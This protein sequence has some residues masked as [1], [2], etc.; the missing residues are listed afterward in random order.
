MAKHTYEARAPDGQI[1]TRTTDRAYTHV[2]IAKH[3]DWYWSEFRKNYDEENGRFEG[4]RFF[5]VTWAGTPELAMKA[6]RTEQNRHSL[7]YVRGKTIKGK[8]MHKDVQAIPCHLKE[9]K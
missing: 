2:I 5:P 8:L 7:N 6:L 4:N 9:K 3:S 1:F